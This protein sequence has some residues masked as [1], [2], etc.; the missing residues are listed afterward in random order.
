MSSDEQNYHNKIANNNSKGFTGK[1]NLNSSK[2]KPAKKLKFII[3][4]LIYLITNLKI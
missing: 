4:L 1:I 3:I 2:S